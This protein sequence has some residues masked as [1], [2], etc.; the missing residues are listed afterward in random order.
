MND[1]KW[2]I[3]SP[4]PSERLEGM[5]Q[6]ILDLA[7]G[8]REPSNDKER[9]ILRE[10]KEIEATGKMLDLPLDQQLCAMD[11]YD[12]FLKEEQF[13][14]HPLEDCVLRT[15]PKDEGWE[16]YIRFSKEAEYKP[17]KNSNIV[18]DAE[19]GSNTQWIT[20]EEYY[21]F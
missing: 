4:E 11:K 13:Y 6:I 20:K 17:V 5:Q 8:K 10:I 21:N 15:I 1:K 14:K 12:R 3:S 7:S 9:E 16:T 18:M 2:K 19:L